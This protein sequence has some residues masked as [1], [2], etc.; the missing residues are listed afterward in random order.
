MVKI[1]MSVSFVIGLFVASFWTNFISGLA[2]FA[3]INA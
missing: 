3:H 2:I 1:C